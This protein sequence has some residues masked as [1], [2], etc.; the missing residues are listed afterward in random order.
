[1]AALCAPW[2]A[3]CESWHK[4]SEWWSKPPEP[5][6]TEAPPP[7]AEAPTE[8]TGTIPPG[9][10]EPLP[11][12]EAEILRNPNSELN[13]GKRHFRA[14]DYGLAEVHFRRAV[15]K[16]PPE[17]RIAAE[18]WLGL[19]ASYDRLRRFELA[20]R[21]YAQALKIAGPL[22]EI[23]NNQGYSYIMRGDY[24]RARAKLMAAYEKEPQNPHILAN[25]EL[26]EK[27]TRGR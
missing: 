19:A 21:A 1:V 17:R 8:T 26:L 20:D 7:G 3:A 24:A 22:A 16:G 15:E 27:S 12:A 18:A 6:Q 9:A 13:L 4:P 2:L 11:A 5:A 25:L 23:L 10:S 14:G